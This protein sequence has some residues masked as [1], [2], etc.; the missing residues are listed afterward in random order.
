MRFGSCTT[1]PS[2]LEKLKQYGYSFAEGNFQCMREMPEEEYEALKSAVEATGV[3]LAGLNCFAPPDVR[4]LSWTDD[5]VDA[6]FESG[7]RRTKPLGLE[8]VVIGSGGS[9]KIPEGMT[10]EV[11]LARLAAMLRRFG[12][13]AER[14]D[15]EVYLEPLRH[16]ETDVINTVSEAA[17]ICKTVNH[18]RV[19]CLADFY[20]MSM[21]GDAFENIAVP[22][23]LLRHIHMATAD[24]RIPLHKDKD[25]L[26]KMICELKKIGYN[27]RVVLE[28]GAEPD[29]ETALREFSEQFTLFE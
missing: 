13:I 27:R 7:V 20:H 8:Y 4:I 9:R 10:R 3:T 1:T 26:L 16:F 28:G 22:G 29:M 23:E 15:I 6:Y 24:R 12:E 21:V 14:Y 2:D 11:G 17:E 18:P 5:E 25:E 19:G